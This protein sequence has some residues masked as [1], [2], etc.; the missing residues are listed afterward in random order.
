MQGTRTAIRNIG[1]AEF[2]SIFH[3]YQGESLCSKKLS[4]YSN[5][6]QDPAM[7][8]IINQMSSQCQNR[9]N[10]LATFLQEAGGSQ[11]LS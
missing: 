11:F 4:F 7:K 3:Q 8:N 1:K 6:C 2:M 5:Q 10:R 9:A